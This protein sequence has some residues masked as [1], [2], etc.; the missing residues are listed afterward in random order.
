MGREPRTH[1]PAVPV[2]YLPSSSFLPGD[3]L[4]PLVICRYFSADHILNLMRD[5]E[6]VYTGPSDPACL[7]CFGTPSCFG[8]SSEPIEAATSGPL[9][10][11]IAGPNDRYT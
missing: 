2:S 9:A 11:R 8:G 10:R 6:P 5:V 1:N 7:S 4:P 3:K